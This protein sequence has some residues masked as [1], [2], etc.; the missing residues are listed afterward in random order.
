[1]NARIHLPVIDGAA[2]EIYI[3]TQLAPALQPR[4]VVILDNLATHK[5]VAAAQALKDRK[6]WFLFL[7]P[8]R[9]DRNPIEM[10]FSKLKAHLRRTGARTFEQLLDAIGDICEL[11]TP[12]ECWNY[13]LAA[14]Y[15]ST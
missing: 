15:A 5:N 11:F 1:V 9:P 12:D 3:R 2:F 7:P 13:M 8:Y 14:G 4:T 6:C 10:A